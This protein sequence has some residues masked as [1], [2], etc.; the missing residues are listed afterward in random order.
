VTAAVTA[1]L[2]GDLQ[3][4]HLGVYQRE[5]PAGPYSC[6][7]GLRWRL[8]AATPREAAA[9][10]QWSRYQSVRWRGLVAPSGERCETCKGV[11]VLDQGP[12]ADEREAI[13]PC[14]DC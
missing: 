6:W 9:A 11:G 12:E 4:E 10:L 3:P 5:F 8:D 1:W 14:P 7:D 13:V 2:S